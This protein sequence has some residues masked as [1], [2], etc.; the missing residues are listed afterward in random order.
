MPEHP[1]R[2]LEI[3]PADEELPLASEQMLQLCF[4]LLLITL[5]VTHGLQ[6]QIYLALEGTESKKEKI[7]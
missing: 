4:L 5:T 2:N 7:D 6:N 3:S 1:L